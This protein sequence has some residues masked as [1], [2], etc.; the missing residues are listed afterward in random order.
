MPLKLVSYTA[1]VTNSGTNNVGEGSLVATDLTGTLSG[2]SWSCSP[3]NGA[4]CP[5]A[6][7]AGLPNFTNDA[8]CQIPVGGRLDFTISGTTSA[9]STQALQFTATSGARA[10]TQSVLSVDAGSGPSV[11]GRVPVNVATVDRSTLPVGVAERYRPGCRGA[12]GH[13]GAR[14]TGSPT[15]SDG[16]GTSCASTHDAAH[17]TPRPRSR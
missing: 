9:T 17:V 8:I 14:H 1:T 4:T 16:L 11:D 10:T 15:H 12:V 7:G 13:P 3:S 5:A 2:V 6:C